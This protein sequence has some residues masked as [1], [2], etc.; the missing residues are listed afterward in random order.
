MEEGQPHPPGD[1][2]GDGLVVAQAANRELEQ[3]LKG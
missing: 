3:Q 2:L 1:P